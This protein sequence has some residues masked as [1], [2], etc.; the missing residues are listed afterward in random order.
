MPGKTLI[1]DVECYKN[2]FFVGIKR[3]E[4]KVTA[5]FEFSERADFDRDKLRAIMRRN[6]IVTF[7]GLT[8][9]AAMIWLA[10]QGATNEEL[11]IASDRIIKGGLKYWEVEKALDVHI[12]KMD[13]ID[14]IEP[15]PSVMTSLK[16]LNGRLHG[17]RMQD[18]PFPEDKYLTFAEMQETNEYCLNDLDATELLFEALSEPIK[19]RE[20]LG[21]IYD[22]DLRSKSDAQM[23]EAI[24]RSRVQKILG[25]KVE[26]VDTK[27]GTTFKYDVPDFFKFRTPQMQHI[28]EKLRETVFIIGADGKSNVLSGE[29]EHKITIGDSVYSMGIGGLHSTE[30]KRSAYSDAENVLIDA[31]VAGQY[32]RIIL[33]LGLFPKALGPAFLKVYADLMNDRLEAKKSGDKVRDKAG[34]IALNGAYGKLGSRYSILYAP[35]LLL[36]VTLTGQLSLLMLI[37]MAELAGIPVISGNTDGVIFNCPR[38]MAGPIVKDRVKGGKL[39]KIIEEWEAATGFVMEANEYRSIHNSSVNTYIAIMASGKVKRKGPI[40]NPWT[41][42]KGEGDI[43]DQLC[44]NPQMTICSDAVL[45]FLL[46]GT[47]IDRTIREAT[48]IRGFLTVVNAAGGATWRDEYLGK[49]VRYIWST[50][51]EAIIKVK[52]HKTTGRRPKVPKTDGCRPV[53]T[54]PDEMPDDIDY[55]RYIEEAFKILNDIGYE[56]RETVLERIYTAALAAPPIERRWVENLVVDENNYVLEIN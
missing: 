25:R 3:Y 10:I 11:K 53:M 26:R 51:G 5:G 30:K 8:Y 19:L 42:R 28:V 9:D 43:R 41:T 44:K 16:T 56:P 37:E 36:A 39:A 14:L 20:E 2:Y 29:K 34:K 15:T 6:R 17:R 12:P 7:N 49:V 40:G 27:P 54:L 22:M 31:D 33:K 18:L 23:G 47:P 32:P 46:D 21:A 35:H 48:D 38:S 45:Q 50:D 13:H 55:E 52:P 4:D 24:I 1:T